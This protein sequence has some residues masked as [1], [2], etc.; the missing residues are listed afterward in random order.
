M[1]SIEVIQLNRCVI[2]TAYQSTPLRDSCS[3]VDD[4]FIICADG[5]YTFA[6]AEGILPDLVIGDFDSGDLS[7]LESDLKN[8]EMHRC[9]VI[10]IP[11]EKDDTDTMLCLK[12][13]IELGYSDFIILGGLG[14]RLDHTAANLQT[15]CY[16]A[17]QGKNVWFLDGKNHATVR[18][19]GI[20]MI[21]RL[22]GFKL[23]VFSFGD[24]CHGVCLS[25]VKYPLK[26]YL[27]KNNFP[28]GVSN[29]F[30][31]KQAAIEHRTGRLLII[32]SQD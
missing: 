14:G 17:E 6:R 27:L 30:T 1:R 23:S 28:I 2:I 11:A 10:R 32:L 31:E 22:E 29:E 8:P 26:D 5:G 18:M 16:A 19:P 25:G 13:G 20:F 12:Y 3:F 21:S 24:A 9:K 15:L 4:D 7:R